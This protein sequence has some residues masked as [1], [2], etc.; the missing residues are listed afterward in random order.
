[1]SEVKDHR[2]KKYSSIKE[3]VADYGVDYYVYAGR[4]NN[5]YTKKEALLGKQNV[6]DHKGNTYPTVKAMCK[7]YG[8][9]YSVYKSRVY[10]G[11]DKGKALTTPNKGRGN[12]R[13]RMTVCVDHKGIEYESISEMCKKYKISPSLFCHRRERGWSLADALTKK[14]RRRIKNKK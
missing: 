4:I 1:M 10:N 11:W 6:T 9:S 8:I 7:A 5:G 14:K 13:N 2:G 12:A 3:M